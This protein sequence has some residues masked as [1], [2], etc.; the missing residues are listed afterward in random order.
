LLNIRHVKHNKNLIND[1]KVDSEGKRWLTC[2]SRDPNHMCI[3]EA[4]GFLSSNFN[5]HST[6]TYLILDMTL[7]IQMRNF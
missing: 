4:G 3:N 6:K 1:I 7:R 5:T 2:A